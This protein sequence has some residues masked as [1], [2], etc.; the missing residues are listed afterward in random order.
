MFLFTFCN[1]TLNGNVDLSITKEKTKNDI[2]VTKIFHEP[3][4]DV[5]YEFEEDTDDSIKKTIKQGHCYEANIGLILCDL[6]KRGST[7]IDIGSHIGIHTIALS[8]KVGPKGKVLSFEPDFKFYTELLNN[9]KINGCQ[10]VLPIRKAL[11]ESSGQALL[12]TSLHPYPQI[13]RYEDSYSLAYQADKHV[14]GELVDM[15]SL[16]SLNVNNLSLIK[17]DVENYEY[18]ILKGAE[19]T[20]KR[21]KP[22][23]VFECW[24]GADYNKSTPKEKANF[25]RVISL[26]KSYGYEI[27]VIY[28]NDF[29][30]FPIESKGKLRQYSNKFK[31]LDLDNFDIG[32]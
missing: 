30:A 4:F 12:S 10:N 25:D 26:I 19:E 16:D 13:I 27:Y 18:F 29:I 32:L 9:L 5:Y 1:I 7:V 31:K 21:N 8:R 6:A 15:I 24:I 11:S 22:V 17:M 2:F 14:A 3:F 20:I 28:A 23:I